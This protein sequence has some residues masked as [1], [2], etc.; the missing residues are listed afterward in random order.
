MAALAQETYFS[1]V[2]AAMNTKGFVLFSRVTT[3]QA[4]D[5][6]YQV[7]ATVARDTRLFFHYPN[8]CL[9]ITLVYREHDAMGPDLESYWSIRF[10]YEYLAARELVQA[11][12]IREG[13]CV[14]RADRHMDEM[15][16]WYRKVPLR[17]CVPGQELYPDFRYYTNRGMEQRMKAAS[18]EHLRPNQIAENVWGFIGKAIPFLRKGAFDELQVTDFVPRSFPG[19]EAGFWQHFKEASAAIST[20]YYLWSLARRPW[21]SEG[22]KR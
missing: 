1:D 10:D 19:C 17:D 12:F 22:L 4:G 7:S 16:T 15:D 2:I 18:F 20:R 14:P 3:E 11:T 21:G 8:T 6:K 9:I 5:L 13:E